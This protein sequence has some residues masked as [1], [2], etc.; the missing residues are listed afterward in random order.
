LCGGTHAEHTGKLFPFRL[1]SESSIATGVRRIEATTGLATVEYLTR[2]LG[3]LERVADSL[4]TTPADLET[5]L[6][7][8]LEQ[9]AEL[10]RRAS[11]LS[12]LLAHTRTLPEREQL[13]QE[14]LR[15]AG[16]SVAI[17]VHEL[18]DHWVDDFLLKRVNHLKQ[19]SPQELHILLSGKRLLCA[20]HDESD[21]KLN[22][23]KV[24]SCLF[25]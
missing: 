23:G 18:R 20:V 12:S 6:K 9:Q 16:A 19:T 4:K 21:P 3:V 15:P 8:L 2:S 10:S 14:T 13:A 25:L 11:A 22:A 24:C 7:R 5:R 1:G 17:V